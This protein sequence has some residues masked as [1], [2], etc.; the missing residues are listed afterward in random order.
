MGQLQPGRPDPGRRFS[1]LRSPDFP[2]H[3]SERPRTA[4]A[5]GGGGG[6]GEF[7]PRPPQGGGEE[8]DEDDFGLWE[9]RQEYFCS[10]LGVSF[11]TGMLYS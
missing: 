6:Q 10:F 7:G 4:E 9:F 2:R 8:Y 1:P 5:E 11:V 3:P